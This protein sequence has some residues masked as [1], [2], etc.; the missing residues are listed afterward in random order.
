MLKTITALSIALKRSVAG[1]QSCLPLMMLS[2]Y[3]GFLKAYWYGYSN[4]KIT[5][6]GCNTTGG[7]IWI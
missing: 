5:K 1:I 2:A 3:T 6:E 7:I 4:L